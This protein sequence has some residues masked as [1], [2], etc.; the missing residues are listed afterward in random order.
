VL[1]LSAQAL[2]LVLLLLALWRIAGCGHTRPSTLLL[3]LL[4]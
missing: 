2:Q 1:L 3:L 4:L